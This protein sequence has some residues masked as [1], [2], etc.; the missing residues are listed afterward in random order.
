MRLKKISYFNKPWFFIQA[1]GFG[2]IEFNYGID[3][4]KDQIHVV[5]NN[6]IYIKINKA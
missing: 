1:I 4:G 3:Q 2:N 6:T 5:H